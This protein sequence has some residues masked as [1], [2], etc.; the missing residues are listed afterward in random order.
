MPGKQRMFIFS[1][2]NFFF[3]IAACFFISATLHAQ[4]KEKDK[5]DFPNPKNVKNLLF[6]V[7][8]TINANTLIYTLNVNKD[9]ELNEEEPI[10]I[11][12]VNYAS[13]STVESLNYIQ[14]KY[15]YGV[16]AQLLDKEKK[17]YSFVFVSYKKKPL[18]LIKSEVDNKYHVFYQM[19][20]EMV[21]LNSVFI[22]IEGG[23]FW[24]PKIKYIDVSATNLKNEKVS[25]R[26]IP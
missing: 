3:I 1:K 21:I 6:Y 2:I 8:R 12:W 24:T 22:K 23:S 17:T 5:A 10:K 26:V 11:N 25:E 14:R 7:Q 16:D 19:K 13:D 15:A 20:N 4:K 18:Y 9:G